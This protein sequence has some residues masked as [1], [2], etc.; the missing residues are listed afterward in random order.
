[1]VLF[2]LDKPSAHLKGALFGWIQENM[3][4]LDASCK[5]LEQM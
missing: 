4:A 1:M 5:S 3:K 2:W